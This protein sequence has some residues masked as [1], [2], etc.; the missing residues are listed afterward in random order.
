M[1]LPIGKHIRLRAL[2][3]SGSPLKDAEGAQI[4]RSYTPTTPPHVD[5]TVDFVIKVY[6]QGKMTQFLD[7]LEVG[8]NVDFYGPIGRFT[9][10]PNAYQHLGMVAGG[11][12][13]TPMYQVSRV[14]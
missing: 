10:T 9:Y 2:D 5:G 4:S 6:P 7:K 13:I 12:G 3:A 11:T 1:G 8:G 14:G